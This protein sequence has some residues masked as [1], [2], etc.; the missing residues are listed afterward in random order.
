MG[1]VDDRQVKWKKFAQRGHVFDQ[2]AA[3]FWNDSG[4]SAKNEITGEQRFFFFKVITDMVF[5]VS[6]GVNCA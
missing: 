5:C 4:T 6:G 2:S 1:R 3:F